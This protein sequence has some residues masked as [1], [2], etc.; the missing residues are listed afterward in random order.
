MRIFFAKELAYKLS[1]SV[2]KTVYLPKRK[3]VL[4]S[5]SAESLCVPF[6]SV[7]FPDF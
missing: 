4:H 1:F 6:W 7:F 2:F 5:R 3:A